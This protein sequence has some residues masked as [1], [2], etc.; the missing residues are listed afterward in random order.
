MKFLLEYNDFE[1]IKLWGIAKTNP[2][3]NNYSSLVRK[4]L[5]EKKNHFKT[6]SFTSL[7][8]LVGKREGEAKNLLLELFDK[9]PN[10]IKSYHKI[11]Y[12]KLELLINEISYRKD[13]SLDIEVYNKIINSFKETHKKIVSGQRL[14][15]TKDRNFLKLI[16]YFRH[17]LFD[18]ETIDKIIKLLYDI[19]KE[20]YLGEYAVMNYLSTKYKAKVVDPPK[21]LDIKHG[22]DKQILDDGGNVIKNVQI[23]IAPQVNLKDFKGYSYIFINKTS[24]DLTHLLDD[25]Q[26]WD[27][28]AIVDG[29][30]IYTVGRENILSIKKVNDKNFMIKCNLGKVKKGKLSVSRDNIIKTL[31]FLD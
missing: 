9:I 28:L 21:E 7:R 25:S 2:P 29:K 26:K 5:N 31:D 17:I 19:N 18:F 12:P 10:N 4:I 3:S 27:G 6:S 11:I 23:K 20:A 24:L 14:S 16:Y 22:I 8:I 30:H 15:N 13:N 1:N